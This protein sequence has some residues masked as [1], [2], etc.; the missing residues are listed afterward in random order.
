[1]AL[2]QLTITALRSHRDRPDGQHELVFATRD[3][4]QLDAAN[5][6]A[7]TERW[8]SS[9]RQKCKPPGLPDDAGLPQTNQDRAKDILGAVGRGRSP[10][11]G[12]DTPKTDLPPEAPDVMQIT[13]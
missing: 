4:N 13:G 2:P 12:V 10:S 9:R 3:G 6:W 1:M 7:C 5:T 11:S 8:T